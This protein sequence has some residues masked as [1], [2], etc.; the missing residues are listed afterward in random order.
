VEG[1][2]PQPQ[3]KHQK[4]IS[5]AFGLKVIGQW[6]EGQRKTELIGR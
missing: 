4:T 2:F 6:K 5:S 1:V 3:K